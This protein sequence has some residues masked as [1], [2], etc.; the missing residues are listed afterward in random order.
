MQLEHVECRRPEQEA[1]QQIDHRRAHRQPIEKPPEQ[2]DRYQQYADEHEPE[3][4]HR[5]TMSYRRRIET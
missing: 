4:G 3:C 5:R 2:R 1:H